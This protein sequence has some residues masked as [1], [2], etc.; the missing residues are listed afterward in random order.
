MV[1]S[2]VPV[3]SVTVVPDVTVPPK[4]LAVGVATRELSIVY[5]AVNTLLVVFPSLTPIAIIV[6]AVVMEMGDEYVVLLA[7]GVLPSVV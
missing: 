5:A 1:A 4:G 6:I 7:V 3:E 2:D